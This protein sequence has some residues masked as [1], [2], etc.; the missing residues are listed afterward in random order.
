MSLSSWRWPGRLPR[1]LLASL[2]WLVGSC[3]SPAEHQ[4]ERRRVVR[5][6]LSIQAWTNEWV[7]FRTGVAILR[8]DGPVTEPLGAGD[9]H[10]QWDLWLRLES[11]GP[12]AAT[13]YK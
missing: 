13:G 11:A 5:C 7:L 2:I 9:S 8:D 10:N 12:T 3:S 4:G 1:Y 6:R